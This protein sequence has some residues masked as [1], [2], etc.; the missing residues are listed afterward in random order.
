ML[1]FKCCLRELVAGTRYHRAE[2]GVESDGL[3]EDK[4]E[5]D[6]EVKREIDFVG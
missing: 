4:E 2:R 6:E 1:H 5:E 3:Q